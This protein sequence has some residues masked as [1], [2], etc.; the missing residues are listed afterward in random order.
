MRILITGGLGFIGS[1]LCRKLEVAGH[2]GHI[3]RVRR[4]QIPNPGHDKRNG[5]KQ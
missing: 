1:H 2:E 3:P 4:E 5:R